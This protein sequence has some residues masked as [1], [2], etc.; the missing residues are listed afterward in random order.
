MSTIRSMRN[1]LIIYGIII[2]YTSCILIGIII[3]KNK[4]IIV[5]YTDMFILPIALF[6]FLF[7]WLF[8]FTYEKKIVIKL[9]DITLKCAE[10]YGEGNS[11]N[12]IKDK[13]GLDHINQVKRR[14]EI[15]CKNRS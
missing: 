2:S 15:F 13:L 12:D 5:N 7:M 6:S 3:A 14:I 4:P 9:D 8:T 1:F 10:L 11:Y